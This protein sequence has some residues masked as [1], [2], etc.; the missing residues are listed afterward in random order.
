MEHTFKNKN[1]TVDLLLQLRLSSNWRVSF[2]VS[3]QSQVLYIVKA[4]KRTLCK[5]DKPADRKF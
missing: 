1:F 2:E 3:S 5:V 4:Q